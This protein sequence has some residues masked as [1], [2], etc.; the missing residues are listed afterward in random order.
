LASEQV[1]VLD[2]TGSQTTAALDL[3]TATLGTGQAQR[4]VAYVVARA[5][6]GGVSELALLERFRLREVE[7][8]PRAAGRG[9]RGPPPPPAQHRPHRAGGDAG[10]RATVCRLGRGCD[11]PQYRQP[12]GPLHRAP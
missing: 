4:R 10:W 7:P 8:P 9:P 2:L 12:H 5:G 3:V 11:H 1:R 6:G